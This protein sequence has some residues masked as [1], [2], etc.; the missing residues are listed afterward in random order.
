[1]FSLFFSLIVFIVS[2]PLYAQFPWDSLQK[3]DEKTYQLEINTRGMNFFNEDKLRYFVGARTEIHPS[4]LDIGAYYTYSFTEKHHYFRVYEMAGKLKRE[5]GEWIL[6]RKTKEWSWDDGFWNRNLWEPVYNED[7]LRPQPAGLIGLFRDFDYSGGQLS[8][9]G[10]FFFLPDSGPYFKQVDGQ[11][12]SENPWFISPSFQKIGNIVPVYQ[13]ENENIISIKDLFQFSFAGRISYEGFY[14]AYAHKPMNELQISIPEFS[15]PLDKKL[16]GTYEKGY[17]MDIPLKSIILDH[18][19]VSA[20][21]TIRSM[22]L[23]EESL[24]NT[25]YLFSAAATYFHPESL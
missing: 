1:M 17:K 18:H 15:L 23:P 13:F 21:W 5:D 25:V 24:Y 2:F 7:I 16:Q 9:F 3:D 14:L 19:I 6:G 20:G 12:V 22:E 11:L 8:L 10:S 4:F